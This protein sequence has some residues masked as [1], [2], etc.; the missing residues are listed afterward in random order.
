[1]MMM[2]RLIHQGTLPTFSEKWFNLLGEAWCQ[3][4]THAPGEVD[5][6]QGDK[7]RR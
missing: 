3:A 7:V 6:F 1:M 4:E 5:S 2:N